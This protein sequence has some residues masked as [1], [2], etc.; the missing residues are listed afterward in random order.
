MSKRLFT[1]GFDKY[2]GKLIKTLRVMIDDK[3]GGFAK[4]ANIIGERGGL[5]GDIRKVRMTS[6][7]IVRDVM[8]YVDDEAQLEKIRAAIAAAQGLRLMGMM[9]ELDGED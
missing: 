4:V 3:P 6:H 2:G 5:L 9:D 1:D 7:H 8:V